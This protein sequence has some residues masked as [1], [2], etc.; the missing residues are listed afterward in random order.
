MLD[1]VPKNGLV[2]V[3]FDVG[4]V[5]VGC[6]P[7]RNGMVGIQLSANA[8]NYFLKSKINGRC[9]NNWLTKALMDSDEPVEILVDGTDVYQIASA[10]QIFFAYE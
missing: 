2:D 6:V 5:L 1:V 4:K 3:R 10:G 7:A 9:E 8:K